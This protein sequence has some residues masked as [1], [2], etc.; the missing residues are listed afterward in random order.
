[1]SLYSSFCITVRPKNGLHG[2]HDDAIVK[3]I[4][5]APYWSYTYE[6]EAESRHL[7]AQL[8]FSKQTTLDNIR[9]ALYRIG[10]ANDPDWGNASQKV[11]A[12]GVRIAYSDWVEYLSKDNSPTSKLPE[13]PTHEDWYPSKEE[14][15]KAQRS[16]DRTADAYFHRLRE[17]WIEEKTEYQIHQFTNVDIAQFYYE[18]MFLKKTIAV[19]RDPKMRKNN[20]K[21][22]LHYIYPGS[23]SAMEM[24]LTEK[25]IEIYN[26]INKST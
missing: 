24:V 19:V 5:R 4:E 16:K 11:Q 18:Q 9:K 23:D 17:L 1:M 26:L 13:D 10:K 2:D 20:A 8:W 22:L 21:C 25:D 7:H 3:W 15:A 12:S 6:M 14:Q